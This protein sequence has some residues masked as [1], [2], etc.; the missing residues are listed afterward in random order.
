MNDKPIDRRTFLS[1]LGTGAA[2]LAAASAGLGAL[3]GKAS[4]ATGTAD[5]LFGF[6]T[7]RVTG[8]FEPISPSKEDE[9]I[10]PP[11]YRYDVVA[12]M[13]DVIN[14]AGERFGDGADYNAY[15]PIN[16]SNEHGL[17]VTNHEYTSIFSIGPVKDGKMTPEQVKKN[18]QYLGMS[19]IEVRRG[20][21][22][23]WRMD[24]TSR[25]ARR[26]DGFTS[27]EL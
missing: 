14:A 17:L 12:A 15:F 22:G 26:I 1:Y 13:D 27:F 8:F 16:G 2:A 24:T 9:L 6:K 19:V 11:G 3:E 21:D 18:L 25:Y 7:N 10:L 20:S 4:A 23:A 5:H